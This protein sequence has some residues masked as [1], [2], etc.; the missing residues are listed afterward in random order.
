MSELPEMTHGFKIAVVGTDSK[1]SFE[2]LFKYRRLRIKD[3][4]ESQ[5]W[6]G[7]KVGD[8][9]DNEELTS[10]YNVLAMLRFGITD[11]PDWWEGTDKG[12]ELYDLNVIWA[13]F[14]EVAKFEN[15]WAEDLQ[16]QADEVKIATP[17]DDDESRK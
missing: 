11:G 3:R 9:K 5:R 14:E 4:L 2:G 1:R 16:K 15:K 13:I 8:Q 10:L 6:Y 7:K 12:L 17:Q